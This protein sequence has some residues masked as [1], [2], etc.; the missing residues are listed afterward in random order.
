MTGSAFYR[1]W[2]LRAEDCFFV[3]KGRGSE[4]G[5]G[6]RS[7]LSGAWRMTG[8]ARVVYGPAVGVAWVIRK[9]K[10]RGSGGREGSGLARIGGWRMTG[11]AWTL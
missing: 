9:E 8:S 10:G 11:S 6:S 3:R 4:G 2:M 5:R 1:R 7:P